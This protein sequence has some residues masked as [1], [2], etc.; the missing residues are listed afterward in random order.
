MLVRMHHDPVDF[1]ELVEPF[2]LEHEAENTLPIGIAR[3]FADQHLHDGLMFSVES[4]PAVVAV[5]VKTPKRNVVVTAGPSAS[6]VALARFCFEYGLP[7]PGVCGPLA[8]IADFAAEWMLLTGES[9]RTRM[10]LRQY[11][12]DHVNPVPQ[13][14][15][16]FR[17][18]RLGEIDHIELLVLRFI[19]EATH[20]GNEDVRKRCLERIGC[21]QVGV[22]D[23]GGI[24]CV[25][26]CRARTPNSSHITCVYTPPDLR[27]RGYAS[28]LVAKMA[29][30]ELAAG[31][32]FCTLYTDL[33]NITSNHIYQSIGFRPIQDAGDVVFE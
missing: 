5:G 15:G 22:W 28:A 21:G 26:E 33:G 32:R 18:A 8:S 9:A 16:G 27:K 10:S 19:A 14:A 30:R 7:V 25:A 4:G 31:K 29:S 24:V 6:M 17:L 13:P 3:S 20:E 23:D 2:L 1:L 12:L 11:K